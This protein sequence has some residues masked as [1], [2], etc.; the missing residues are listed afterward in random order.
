VRAYSV[1]QNPGQSNGQEVFVAESFSWGAFFFNVFWALY[2]RAWA[3]FGVALLIVGS[4][5]GAWS[6][7]IFSA[8]LCFLVGTV[9]SALLGWQASYFLGEKLEYKGFIM[10]AIVLGRDRDAAE[11]RF[12]S[13]QTLA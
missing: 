12:F 7:G 3:V 13:R 2:V 4:L 11:A 8:Q 9:L 1:Y 5:Y 10:V 6:G